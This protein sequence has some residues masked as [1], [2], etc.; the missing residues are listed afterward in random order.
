MK[1]M[2][3]KLL[4][5][6]AAGFAFSGTANAQAQQP[7]NVS[8]TVPNFCIFDVSSETTMAFNLATVAT[9]TVDFTAET[10]LAYR[11]SNG[12]NTSIEISSGGSGDST[13]RELDNA[14]TPLAY[15]LY[16]DNGYGTIWGDSGT[17][18]TSAVAI[19]GTGMGNLV[20]RTVF[21]RILLSAAQAAEPGTYSDTV[22]VTILP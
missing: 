19:L 2:K 14:G 11:C 7:I 15:N 22:T 20:T 12:F 9:A 18:G 10:D 21:G 1:L 6:A 5:I 4:L 8:A 3:W 16:T 13:A 17:A